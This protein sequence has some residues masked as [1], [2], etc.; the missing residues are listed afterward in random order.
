[1]PHSGAAAGVGIGKLVE[2]SGRSGRTLFDAGKA[3]VSMEPVATVSGNKTAAD[4][5]GV[6]AGKKIRITR[7]DGFEREGIVRSVTATTVDVSF[8]DNTVA[9]PFDQIQGVH[10]LR[11]HIKRGAIIGLAVG[12]GLGALGV[13]ACGSDCAGGG[14]VVALSA[15][16]GAGFGVGIGANRSSAETARDVCLRRPGQNDHVCAGANCVAHPKKAW[17]SR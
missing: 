16:F 9:M 12:G 2:V 7:P 15:G 13:A 5:H 3:I 10:T 8:G 17:R 14:G 6:K 11:N 1:M 4:F